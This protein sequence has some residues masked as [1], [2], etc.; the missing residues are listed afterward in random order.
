[1]P[2]KR[3]V[4]AV[5][6]TVTACSQGPQGPTGPP[7]SSG[8]TPP[9]YFDVLTFGA[10]PDL[11]SLD[12]TGSFQSALDAAQAA[13]GGIVWVPQGRFWF[14]GNLSIGPNVVLAGAGVGPYD[15]YPDPSTTSTAPTLLPM[16]TSGSA[17]ISI[18]GW[19]S[20]LE[21]ILIHY[22]NQVRPD[23]AGVET[24]G[25]I[26]YPPTVLVRSPSKIFGCTFDNSYIGIQ[27]MVGRV[28]LENLHIGSYR[29]DIIIDQAEDFV[30]LSHITTSVFW[31][32]SLGLGFPQLIDAWVANNSIA[33]TSYRMDA[34]D[35][36]DFDVFWRNTGIAFLDS[37]EGY[38]TTYG[39]ATNLDLE[40]VQ[41]GVVAKSLNSIVAFNFANLSVGLAPGFSGVMIWLPEGGAYPPHVVVEGGVTW[42]FGPQPLK[43]ETGTLRVRD[44]VNIN[45]IGGLPAL[46]IAAPALPPSGI[47]Y[48]STMPA[49]AQ[50][51]ISG[52]SVQDVLI[53]GQS[54][55]L[56]S[57]MFKVAPGEP[58]AVVYVSAPTWSWFLE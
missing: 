33:L 39:V 21:N 42:S 4:I 28:Y 45:P 5:L 46:G 43:V 25:P 3:L 58:I 57:G 26:V 29:N 8:A 49:D 52:G 14:L 9:G 34:L 16:S 56:T 35:I 19:N 1:M 54:T 53:G 7:G 31:D 11:P 36:E 10:K 41:Y 2:T 23:T 18:A 13:G 40:V 24:A 15:P 27:V 44:I 17:F 37:P 22:P 20:A 50:V 32:T 51:S 47:S 30:H 12:S 48:V 6:L 55:S 38:G